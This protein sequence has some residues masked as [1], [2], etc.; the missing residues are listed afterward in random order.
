M[1]IQ[2]T[3]QRREFLLKLGFF[4]VTDDF[5]YGADKPYAVGKFTWAFRMPLS[6]DGIMPFSEGYFERHTDEELQQTATA[7]LLREWWTTTAFDGNALGQRYCGVMNIYAKSVNGMARAQKQLLSI[8]YYLQ[9]NAQ[10]NMNDSSMT[11]AT[12]YHYAENAMSGCT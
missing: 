1:G 12:L 9:M 11:A 4:P 8:I 2:M 3:M 5:W 6:P 10:E 7:L